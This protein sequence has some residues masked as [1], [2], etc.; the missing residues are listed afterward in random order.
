MEKKSR[1]KLKKVERILKEDDNIRNTQDE[2]S[3]VESTMKKR[4]IST[5][6]NSHTN[7]KSS[8]SQ[9]IESISRPKKNSGNFLTDKKKSTLLLRLEKPKQ[10]PSYHEWCLFINVLNGII[11][12]KEAQ[13][14]YKAFVG[15]GNNSILI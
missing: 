15:K 11:S 6:T 10:P 9:K 2:T 8:T 5:N 3:P 12:E 7:S 4:R 13:P 14:T 1:E